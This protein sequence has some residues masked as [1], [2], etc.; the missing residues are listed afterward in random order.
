MRR[1]LAI[2]RLNLLSM[3]RDRGE[4]VG[5]I[6]LPLI[7]TW[8]F[9]MA[10]GNA[11]AQRPV[12]VPVADLDGSVYSALVTAELEKVESFDVEYVT[13]KEARAAVEDGEVAQ[14]V[15][16]PEGFGAAIEGSRT[17]VV[18][19]V[20]DPGSTGRVLE[21]VDGAVARLAASAEAARLTHD[22]LPA[23]GGASAGGGAGGDAFTLAGPQSADEFRRAFAIAE[24]FW[25][26]APVRVSVSEVTARG[27]HAAELSAPSN[28]QYSLGFT[29]FFVFMVALGSAGGVLEERELGTLRRML[30]T[31]V[32][33][34]ELLAGKV[35]GV[36]AVAG[37][38]AALL[39]GVGAVI[40]GVPWGSHPVAVGIML[41]S[42]VFA[43]TG[44]GV[45]TSALVRTR[46]Q[47]SALT[48]VLSVALAMLG[49]CYW[50]I[51]ITS[52]AMQAA[53]R[54]TPTGWAMAGLTDI[55]ARGAG[56]GAVLLP[57]GVL[58]AFG[59][60][61]L[62]VGTLRLRLE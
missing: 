50:P 11:N 32:R 36:A 2:A 17:A 9:G 7:L 3:F 54:F 56:V 13:E 49:G 30:V 24:T 42:L 48:P 23:G 20:T 5:V 46:S 34:S 57:V 4:L 45:M 60:V 15:I 62:T 47:M 37:F 1:V 44:L 52:P 51:E 6:V 22:V 19:T 61:A 29:V 31:P 43:A 16:L 25:D 38:E 10:M 28:T 40:F 18:E 12:R 53:A 21:V 27:A 59:V 58:A 35:L 14:A 39:V 33:R 8:F 55:V 41:L 26:P